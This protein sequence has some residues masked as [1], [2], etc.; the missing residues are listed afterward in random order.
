MPEFD[1][2]RR[3]RPSERQRKCGEGSPLGEVLTRSWRPSKR[4]LLASR[5]S[6]KDTDPGSSDRATMAMAVMSRDRM[7]G[8]QEAKE[9]FQIPAVLVACRCWPSGLHEAVGGRG[10]CLVSAR[11]LCTPKIPQNNPPTSPPSRAV[12]GTSTSSKLHWQMRIRPTVGAD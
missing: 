4:P 10:A 6:R 3:P 12:L 5:S 1:A 9:A 8:A 2:K 11:G 7:S